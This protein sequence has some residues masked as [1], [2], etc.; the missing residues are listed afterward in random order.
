M[1]ECL[2]KTEFHIHVFQLSQERLELR[3]EELNRQLLEENHHSRRDKRLNLARLQQEVARQK[4][5]RQLVSA[6]NPLCPVSCVYIYAEEL[7]SGCRNGV[8]FCQAGCYFGISIDLL[9][10]FLIVSLANSNIG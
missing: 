5:E 1:F 9:Q 10:I 2:K 3:M 6:V 4:S 7:I 8:G